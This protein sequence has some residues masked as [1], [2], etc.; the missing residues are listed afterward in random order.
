M[1]EILKRCTIT[2]QNEAYFREGHYSMNVQA[3]F[4]VEQFTEES[5]RF[6][7]LRHEI[8]K[9]VVG[10]D[11]IIT[12]IAMA[13]VCDGHIVLEG[14]PGVAKTTMIKSIARALGLS[15]QRIQF[16]PDLLPADLIGTVIYNQKSTDFEVRQGPIF[17]HLILADEINRAPAKVQSALLEA[18]EERQVTIGSQTFMLPSPFL[19]FATQNPVEQEGTYNLPEAQLDR[20]MFKLFV[21]YPSPQEEREILKKIE[22]TD[23]IYQILT[24]SD[25]MKARSCVQSVYLDERVADYIVSLV[26][27]TR[28]LA[29]AGLSDY[30]SYVRYGVSPRA[31]IA[32]YKAAKAYAFI[33]GRQFVIPDDVKSVATVTLRHRLVLTYQAEADGIT[34]DNII[35]KVL[36]KI[37]AP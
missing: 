31:T 4:N 7:A 19:V 30:A 12:F 3:A 29:T 28:N 35:K 5:N 36:Q 37:V 10:Q 23:H 32:L 2:I 14:V 33:K 25:I 24:H 13:I 26:H 34:A 8:A 20:F 17:A 9:V 21:D 15:F 27:A 18:M 6:T 22:K 1:S 16:T 11:S